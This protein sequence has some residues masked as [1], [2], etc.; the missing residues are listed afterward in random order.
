MITMQINK[1]PRDKHSIQ[2]YSKDE[3]KINGVSYHENLLITQNDII[4]NWFNQSIAD[5]T[6]ADLEPV[7]SLQPEIFIIGHEDR[8]LFPHFQLMQDLSVKKIGFEF[9]SVGA[10]CRTFNVLLSEGRNTVLGLL[11]PCPR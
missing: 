5:L 11:L 7:F 3:I 6:R 2:S 9:M 10:A 8:Q 4:K 1:E